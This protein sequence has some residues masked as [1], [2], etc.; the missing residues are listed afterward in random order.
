MYKTLI[1]MCLVIGVAVGQ[2][3]VYR[4]KQFTVYSLTA[5]DRLLTLVDGGDDDMVLEMYCKNN[6]EVP[7][8]TLLYFN[9]IDEGLVG[10]RIC[11][12]LSDDSPNLKEDDEDDTT[13]QSVIDSF[14]PTLNPHS[15]RHGI[16]CGPSDVLILKLWN[17][18][19]PDVSMEYDLR[20]YQYACLVDDT[21][22]IIYE[23][24][25]KEYFEGKDLC[26]DNRPYFPES[27]H[28][29][30]FVS[31]NCYTG[32]ATHGSGGGT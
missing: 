13:C 1:S 20:P 7:H 18:Y 32:P 6:D 25:K 24:G 15:E 19:E 2:L 9:S 23:F 28:P 27:S 11:P 14:P 3:D 31:N 12:A 30:Y 16:T 8:H 5:L 29:P 10:T 26:I 22:Q 4:S 21:L 17:R